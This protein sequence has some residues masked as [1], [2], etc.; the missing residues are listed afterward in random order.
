V[1][2][3]R[4]GTLYQRLDLDGAAFGTPA[5]AA[6]GTVYALDVYG[7]L[8]A[9]PY[10][11][12]WFWD[13]SIVT[14]PLRE[15]RWV[16]FVGSLPS[17]SPVIGADGFI[18]VGGTNSIALFRPD[19][20]KVGQV[21]GTGTPTGG[22]A[23]DANRTVYATTVDSGM[24]KVDF[25]CPNGP[26]VQN[27]H[28]VSVNNTPPLLAHG[29]L[30]LGRTNGNVIKSS[31]DF[32]WEQLFQADGEITAGPVA[33]PYGQILVGTANG[34]L[35]AL[36]EDLEL[37]WQRSIG[38][39]VTSIPASS[40]DAVYIVTGDEMQAYHPYSGVPLW[41]RNLGSGTGSGSVAVGY[42]REL[43]AQTSSGKI[44]AVGEGWSEYVALFSVKSVKVDTRSQVRA[45]W[46]LTAP[47]EPMSIADAGTQSAI[48]AQGTSLGFLL[49]RSDGGDWEDLA[50][51]P[52]GT[53]VYTD[54]SILPNT[55]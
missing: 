18:A 10:Q 27:Q 47:L 54:S 31:T 11:K 44:V 29:S 6:D 55:T 33:G 17:T 1:D 43:Y 2:V 3:L 49:Q 16:N 28:Y 8:Y 50:I 13:G 26:C 48:V 5:I 51:L 15:R 52:P 42:G 12:L 35:Y 46:A 19:G 45:E 22:L 40:F 30:Y 41:S 34:T 7:Q 14:V 39:A 25:F 37:R 53:T 24:L 32:S 36:T 20:K 21:N 38:A 23:V 9:F 4:N